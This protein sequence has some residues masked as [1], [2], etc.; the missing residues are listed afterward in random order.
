M[1]AVFAPEAQVAAAAREQPGLSIAAYN[2]AQTVVSGVAEAVERLVAECR[3][4]GIRCERLHTS[5]AFHSALIEPVLDRLEAQAAALEVRP[6]QRTLIS[7]LT[8]RPLASGQVLDAAYWRRQAR[9]PV[10]FA[11][12]LQS[13]ADQA[14]AV[15]VEL[16]P[17]P[18]L[19]GMA[20]AAWPPGATPPALL[21]TLRRGT[22]DERQL[23][24]TLAQ[25]YV[26]GVTA[27]FAAL[28]ARRPGRKLSL[29][30]YPFQRQRY[31]TPPPRRKGLAAEGTHPLLGARQELA[32]GQV[33][34]TQT[35]SCALQPW[36]QDHR[37][38]GEVVAPGALYLSMALC[39]AEAPCAVS[40]V[41]FREA[42]W[43]RPQESNAARQV[44]LMLDP[45]AADAPRSFAVFSRAESGQHAWTLHAQGKLHAGQHRSARMPEHAPL[46]SLQSL[47]DRLQ[48]LSPETFYERAFQRRHPIRC[49]LS[50]PEGAVD[51]PQRSAGRD[52]RAVRGALPR[53][54]V[55]SG[56]AGRLPAGLR[57]GGRRHPW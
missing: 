36:L 51:R 39:L 35:L 20:A 8:G 27:D 34:Y 10:Q 49:P 17:Q 54:A 53:H 26:H 7:N 25:L 56:P 40:E 1:A 33:A 48:P 19:L 2:G 14:V 24:E 52:H 37:V 57:R 12:S 41:N 42:L 29:P 9:E 46:E 30:T 38:F 21:A 44:Q 47:R 31:W 11:R 13:L 5:Q 16:G 18:V 28:H 4:K 3:A 55:G 32:S 50:R 15:L 23:A 45:A 6:A 43:L 22:D